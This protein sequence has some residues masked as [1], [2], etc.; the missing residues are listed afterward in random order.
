MKAS[1]SSVGGAGG[2][3]LLAPALLALL[4]AVPGRVAAQ[5]IRAT[6][7]GT[8]SDAQ[9]AAMPGV[10]VTVLNVD[11]NLAGA[12]VTDAHGGYLV[13]K[14]QPGRYRVTAALPGF[15]S[16]VR[17]GV[18]LRTAETGTI[19]MTLD[20]GQVEETV[21][22]SGALS[23]VESNQSTLA[24]TMENKR[25]SELP[26]NGRQVYMLLQLT[27]GTFFTQTQFGAQGFSGTRAWDVNGS[28]SIHGSRTG[29]NEFLIDGGAI[30]GTGGWSYAPPVDA[31][32][33]FKVQTA[34]TDASYGRTSGGVVNLTLRS[35]TNQL[36]GSGTVLLRGTALDAN[37]VQNIRNDIS[38]SGHE[39]INGE[40][41]LHGPIVRDKTFFM[42][43]YQGFYENIPFPATGTV[44]TERQRRGDFSQTFNGAGQLVTIYDPLTTRPDPSRP[45]RFIRDPFPGNVIPADR[46]NEIARTLGGFMPA[47]NA[48]GDLTGANNFINSPNLG[49]YRYHSYILRLDHRFSDD[50]RLSLSNSGNWGNERRSENGLPGGPALR[51]DN[52]PTSRKNYL[53][54]LDDLLTLDASTLL[55]TRVSF[56]RFDE[57]HDKEFG[58]LPADLRLPFATPYQLTDEP[59]FPHVNLGGYTDMFSRPPRLARNEIYSLQSSLSRTSG[60]HFLK[61]GGEFRTYRLTRFDLND[62][63]GAYNFNG[64]FTRRD[65][66]QGDAT[67][68]NAF[69]SFLLG[70]PAT[71]F[72]DINPQSVRRYDYYGVF[73]QDEWKINQR[74]SLSLG[75]RWDYQAPVTE[76]NDEIIVGFDAT[77]PSPLQVP[78]LQIR[79]GLLYAGVNG[80]PHAPYRGD[81]NN[82]QPRANFTYKI[83]ERLLGRASYGRSYLALTGAAIEG[84]NQNGY[85]QRTSMVTSVQTGIP[86]R[87]LTNPFPEGF[88]EPLGNALGL[89]TGIGT[90]ITFQNTGF[91]VPYTDQWMAGVSLELPWQ[92][93]LELAYVGNK[94]SKLAVSTDLNAVSRAERDRSIEALG[95]NPSYLTTQVP[96]PFAGLVPGSALNTPT[97][98][99]QQLLR[100]FPQFTQVT[101]NLDNKGWSRYRALEA[102]LNKR[103]TRGLAS[104]VN[105]TWSQLKEATSYL[106]N[107]FE[108]EPFADLSGLDR[109]HHLTA[110][111]LYELPFKGSRLVEGWQVNFLWEYA[112]GVPV[113]YPDSGFLRQDSARLPKG[114]QTLDRWFDNSTR[115]NPRPDGGYAWD[116]YAPNAYRIQRLRFP[117]V[118]ENAIQTMAVSLFKNT[119]V[120]GTTVQLRGELF[121]PFNTKYYGGPNTTVTSAQF[122]RVTPNQF[123]FPRQGQLGLR[124]YF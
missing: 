108:A 19:D 40:F 17:E 44:P 82:I 25:I 102:V 53:A 114:E 124:V 96:N 49:R 92:V 66:Q 103:F 86:F 98:S 57:P 31:I 95:G 12:T 22:V 78:G 14:L 110:T 42:V 101:M 106:N 13:T 81:W 107:G 29:Q 2:R 89:A 65:P 105:Y 46:I 34:S 58:P 83:S 59:W 35:G 120:G 68:G 3:A 67:S 123:N 80:N 55:N 62:L 54:V 90:A 112:S 122:G 36:H 94:V 51:T 76:K 15:K 37:T 87:T 24:Q 72:V 26:L 88:L 61:L 70:F 119:R 116:T 91:E 118:R 64:D 30:S 74:A 8:V 21:T 16:F 121:N 47:P 63:N 77:T 27:A 50:H 7:T 38:N 109:T 43:G 28:V 69:A 10:T 33:E 20:V 79:G 1:R 99:R 111:V 71:A 113:A 100:P 39:Y 48:Q 11:T 32:E 60:R 84:I 23:G 4:T 9:G 45:G 18:T 5:E 75:L 85:S 97:V 117:D 73:V 56:D 41:T 104:T 93:G 6:V 115:N 52:W